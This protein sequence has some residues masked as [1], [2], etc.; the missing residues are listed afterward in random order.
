ML[1]VWIQNLRN[2]TKNSQNKM[3]LRENLR[4]VLVPGKTLSRLLTGGNR[5][6]TACWLYGVAFFSFCSWKATHFITGYR[7]PTI[8]TIAP[9]Y[10][11]VLISFDSTQRQAAATAI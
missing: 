11:S 9:G 2:T 7:G 6:G 4:E 1:N 8:T 5:P 3:N 10:A